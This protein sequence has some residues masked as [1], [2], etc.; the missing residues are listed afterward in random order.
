MIFSGNTWASKPKVQV[1]GAF[2]ANKRDWGGSSNSPQT[3]PDR[4]LLSPPTGPA[5]VGEI[6]LGNHRPN[7]KVR[8]RTWLECPFCPPVPSPC[9]PSSPEECRDV[10]G[11]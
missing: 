7:F 9:F 10:F 5:Y 8:S 3:T 2:Q 11:M 1:M 6:S 4:R